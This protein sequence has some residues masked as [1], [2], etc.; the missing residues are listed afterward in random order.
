MDAAGLAKT[1]A[2][3]GKD[4]L[5]QCSTDTVS[6]P[7]WNPAIL[8]LAVD[9]KLHL[10]SAYNPA[11]EITDLPAMSPYKDVGVNLLAISYNQDDANVAQELASK[12]GYNVVGASKFKA[13]FLDGLEVSYLLQH[14][15]TLHCYVTFQGTWSH[16]DF[17]NDLDA[18][19]V[20]FCGLTQRGETC[21]SDIV[22]ALNKGICPGP[23]VPQNPK[24]T[25]VHRGFRNQLRRMIETKSFE[26]RV[27]AR[28][29]FCSQVD[30]FGHSLGGAMAEMF[31]SC[32]ERPKTKGDYGFKDFSL[33]G[34]QKG[35]P[36]K[37]PVDA[38][39]GSPEEWSVTPSEYNGL[40]NS[41]EVEEAK[42]EGEE[43]AL[44]VGPTS[45]TTTQSLTARSTGSA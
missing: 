31:T 5:H 42:P 23:C 4:L 38:S 32:A 27:H 9:W 10:S 22:R 40:L 39:F 24:D 36:T 16:Q 35:T 41:T 34:W 25:F 3:K 29:P 33:I 8:T 26:E 37:L 43:I 21:C 18:F 12:I 1:V 44:E 17:I 15:T 20:P 7:P 6:F 28:L 19:A 30:V 45:T 14:P 2:N 13:T 11:M